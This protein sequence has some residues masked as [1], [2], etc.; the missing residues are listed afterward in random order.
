MNNNNFDQKTINVLLKAQELTHQ[1]QHFEMSSIHVLYELIVLKDKFIFKFFNNLDIDLNSFKGELKNILGKC[2]ACKKKYDVIQMLS[3]Q[4]LKNVLSSA[5]EIA[6]QFE[7]EKISTKILFLSL[8]ENSLECNNIFVKFDIQNDKIRKLIL[9]NNEFDDCFNEFEEPDNVEKILHKYSRDL[10]ELAL[11]GKL[12]PVIGRDDEIR[13]VI[14][15]LSRR[16][17]NNPVII[18]EAGVGKTAIIEG[19]AERITEK[20][21]PD[22]L[23]GKKIIA[24]DM[25]SLIAGAK[26]RGEFEERLKSVLEEVSESAGEIIL[27]IDE[28][29][30][31]I[32]AGASEGSMDAGNILKPSLARG[33]IHCIGATTTDEYKKHIEKD[34]AF[35]RRFQSVT[36]NEPTIEDTISILRGIRNKYEIHHG[37]KIKDSAIIAASEMSARYITDRHLPDKAIDLLDEAAAKLRTEAD[38]CPMELDEA[39]R[40]KTRLEI[41]IAGLKDE[42]NDKKSKIKI[43]TLK[44]ELVDISLKVETLN[45]EWLLEKNTILDIRTLRK[46]IE[47]VKNKLHD[48]ERNKELEK[49]AELRHGILP[50]LNKK[51]S[52]LEDKL[53]H[54]RNAP[55]MLKEYVDEDDIATTISKWTNIPINKLMEK[56]R[57]KL[58]NLNDSL[59]K[60]VIGQN[61]AV[62]A[63][64]NAVIKSRSGLN[65]PNKPTGSFMFLGPTGV[66]KTELAKALA[67]NLFNDEKSIIRLDMSEY[68]EKHS[69]AKLIGSPPGYVGFDDGGQLTESVR[70]RPYS[71][72][73][74]DEIEKAHPDVFNILLQLLDDG[75]LTDSKGKVID[76]KNTI[77]IMT[78]NIGSQLLLEDDGNSPETKNAVLAQL[79]KHFRPEF[80]NRID[81]IIVFHRLSKE[82]IGKIT[83]IQIQ[84]FSERLNKLHISLSITKRAKENII[85]LGYEP[86]FGARPLKRVFS[87]DIEPIVANMIITGSLV[88][89][90]Q[91]KIAM[92]GNS[93]DFKCTGS[94]IE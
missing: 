20:D 68:M 90:K 27:F 16:K 72:I 73:L 38:S 3:S 74:F 17:K 89:D 88:Q 85:N 35:E 87:Q 1:C 48:A 54:N 23:L 45:T 83:D 13:R 18:G 70:K 44:K 24:L 31:V 40:R 51:L 47:N 21:V 62:K 79:H 7:M 91:L 80:L 84:K 94:Y 28:L 30:T 56:E 25:G 66:G 67:Q 57:E 55:K 61:D 42:E 10:T 2:S 34:P 76:F 53:L 65:D 78:S 93:L 14:Q 75:R 81:E 15:I 49:A 41:E 11:K 82:D 33:E 77:V 36:A 22:G 86:A 26:Y 60:R 19:L 4:D 6:E 71:V 69:V 59:H 32:G 43:N 29:H 9:E 52:D 64:T 8:V 50:N 92:K 5:K 37:I 63:I 58:I 12:D 46:S 39:K